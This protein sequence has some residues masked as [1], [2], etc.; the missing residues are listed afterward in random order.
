[1]TRF[2]LIVP[3]LLAACTAAAPTPA[4]PDPTQATVPVVA[5]AP[6][7]QPWFPGIVTSRVSKTISSEVDA[8]VESLHVSIGKRVREGDLIAKIDDS[9]L[10]R[11]L[12]AAKAAERAARGDAGAAAAQAALARQRARVE[13]MLSRRGVAPAQ[14]AR[15]ALSEARAAGA[16]TGAAASRVDQAR[17]SV[18]QIQALLEKTELRA[19][20]AGVITMIKVREGE[21]ATTG[22]P[23]ARVFDDSDLLVKFAVP[24]EHRKLLKVG[25]PVEIQIEGTEGSLKATIH[26]ISDEL[27]PP[28]N[29]TVVEADLDDDLIRPGQI[30]VAANALVRVLGAPDRVAATAPSTTTPT[31]TAITTTTR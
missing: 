6:V 26:T 27:E 2:L 9:K 25:A 28:V 12:E 16:S 20:V 31:T 23:I 10:R 18:K 8:P 1:M 15:T 3:L 30:R 5:E 29:F 24:S 14:A 22:R 21:M 4:E 17:T 7:E 13:G 19:P 11:D